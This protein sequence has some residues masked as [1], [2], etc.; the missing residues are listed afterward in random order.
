MKACDCK[1]FSNSQSNAHFAFFFPGDGHYF[2]IN[3]LYI[4][5]TGTALTRHDLNQIH[6]LFGELVNKDVSVKLLSSAI[7]SFL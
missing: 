6:T 4:Y 7:T 2:N 5:S 3:V 1:F